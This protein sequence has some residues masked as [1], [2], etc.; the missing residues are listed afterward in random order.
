MSDYDGKPIVGARIE[1]SYA[2]TELRAPFL[3]LTGAD[4]RYELSL[5]EREQRG[6][7]PKFVF[8]SPY[9]PCGMPTMYRLDRRLD[10]AQL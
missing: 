7:A 4:G 9:S 1:V 6:P 5:P 10:V 2:S 8:G 3:V